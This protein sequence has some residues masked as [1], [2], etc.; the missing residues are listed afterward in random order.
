MYHDL[1]FKSNSKLSAKVWATLGIILA[2]KC[3]VI[4][5]YASEHVP[6]P[7]YKNWRGRELTG[8]PKDLLKNTL[9]KT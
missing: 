2:A 6:K 3:I 4:P 9:L 7:A 8:R 1:T 5:S